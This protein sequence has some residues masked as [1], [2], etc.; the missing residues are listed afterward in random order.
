MA[1]G[2]FNDSQWTQLVLPLRA[3]PFRENDA[4][5]SKIKQLIIQL[6]GDGDIYLDRIRIIPWKTA[7]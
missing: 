7:I 2:G 5:N 6:E 4:D 1:P 3:F